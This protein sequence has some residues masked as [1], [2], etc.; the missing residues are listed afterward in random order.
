MER[1]ECL[2]NVLYNLLDDG[3]ENIKYTLMD[4]RKILYLVI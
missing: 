2:Y 4:K 3:E 1:K